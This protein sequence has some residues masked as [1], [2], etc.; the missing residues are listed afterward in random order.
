MAKL[1]A[2]ERNALPAKDFGLPKQRKYP[3]EDQ[4]HAEAA[5]SRASAAYKRGL[6]SDAQLA[7]INAKADRVLGK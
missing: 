3:E 2:A 7:R 1:D 4:G 5:K 6:I